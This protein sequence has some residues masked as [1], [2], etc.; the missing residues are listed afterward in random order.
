MTH[1]V[2]HLTRSPAAVVDAAWVAYRDLR[3]DAAAAVP[4][5]VRV[6]GVAADEARALLDDTSTPPSVAMRLTPARTWRYGGVEEDTQFAPPAAG[7][8]GD[9]RS[10]SDLFN[11]AHE[12]LH[13]NMPPALKAALQA[14]P[15]PA[16]A[17]VRLAELEAALRSA[18]HCPPDGPC[19]CETEEWEQDLRQ[20]RDAVV[21]FLRGAGVGVE[22][23]AGDA[24]DAVP[25]AL[26]GA[27]AADLG[28]DLAGEV[29]F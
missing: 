20:S 18:H 7:P 28:R 15:K 6:L 21:A 9:G 23:R 10:M 11:E 22:E 3:I 16:A 4:E 5:L 17:T 29:P 8:L 12:R 26:K 2:D 13:P 25:G 14:G 1:L 27:Y 24:W 19:V